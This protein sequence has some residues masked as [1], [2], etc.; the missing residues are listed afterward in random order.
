MNWKWSNYEIVTIVTRDCI[1]VDEAYRRLRELEQELELTS[2]SIRIESIRRCATAIHA[3]ERY[4]YKNGP[5]S[6]RVLAETFTADAERVAPL[7]Q[8]KYECDIDSL[9]FVRYLISKLQPHRRFIGFEDRVAH[10]L[11][12]HPEARLRLVRSAYLSLLSTGFLQPDLLQEIRAIYGWEPVM[13]SIQQLQSAYSADPES[14]PFLD[15]GEIYLSCDKDVALLPSTFSSN[16]TTY[17]IEKDHNDGH[18]IQ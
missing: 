16:S 1:T 15:L 4:S 14:F 11:C 2:E 9:L 18:E 6:E 7:E 10:Q 5:E 3:E 12:Q 13:Q 17:L 8:A